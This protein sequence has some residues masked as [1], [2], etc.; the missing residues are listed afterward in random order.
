MRITIRE[1]AGSRRWMRDV[2]GSLARRNLHQ[3]MGEEVQVLTADYLRR[4][5]G[6]RHDTAEALGAA[7]TGFLGT[8]A[9]KVAS[10]GA[11]EADS[12][13]ATLIIDHPGMRRAFGPVTIS[14]RNA[15]SLAIPIH[16]IA[17]GQRARFLWNQLSLFIPKGCN[18]IAMKGPDGKSILPLYILV[19]SVT[20]KQD[21]TLLPSDEEFEGAAIKGAENFCA[22]SKRRAAGGNG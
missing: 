17:Y 12:N 18:F 7:P 14:P 5:A 13:A 6:S 2:T 9:E 10:P 20:Q 19:R 11:L 21:R 8:A 4:L 22:E 3:A 1:D 16:A 15:K